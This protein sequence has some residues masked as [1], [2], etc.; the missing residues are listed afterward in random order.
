MAERER[1]TVV[2]GD[3]GRGGGGTIVAVIAVIALLVVLFL[4][5][6]RG[7]IGGGETKE[8]KAD[9]DISAPSGGGSGS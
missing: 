4:V 7:L 6:G 2:V 8:I 1:E 9:V 3:S 5:F